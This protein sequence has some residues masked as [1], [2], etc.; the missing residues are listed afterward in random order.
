[1]LL[2]DL[3]YLPFEHG[4][5]S[6]QYLIEFNWLKS[7]AYLVSKENRQKCKKNNSIETKP[8]VSM[9][10]L[11]DILNIVINYY[12]LLFLQKKKKTYPTIKYK[13]KSIKT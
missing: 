9:L 8:E 2:C 3:F 6:V 12:L 11:Y 7:N 13:I 4:P 10:Y 1:M 5:L